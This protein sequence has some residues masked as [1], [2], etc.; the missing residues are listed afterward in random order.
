MMA[1]M[2]GSIAVAVL[3]SAGVLALIAP[4]MRK[5]MGGVN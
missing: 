5:L 3:V 2:F 4:W 1:Y